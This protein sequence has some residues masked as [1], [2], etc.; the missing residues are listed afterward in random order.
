MQDPL[1]KYVSDLIVE[2]NGTD[3]P[4]THAALLKDVNEAID[5]ALVEAL[6]LAQLEKLEVA[7]N[8][9]GEVTDNLVEQLLIEA[10]AD[11]EGIVNATLQNFHNNYMKGENNGE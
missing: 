2:K 11:P 3:T 10:G 1:D 5:Q 9:G 6:P 7:V 8:N 4:E